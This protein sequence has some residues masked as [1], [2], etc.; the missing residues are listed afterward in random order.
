METT[1]ELKLHPWLARM[2][3][4]WTYET[5][6]TMPDGTI[7]KDGGTE[8][9]RALGGIWIVASGHGSMGCGEG[10]TQICLG[11]Q[12]EEQHFVGTFLGSMMPQLWMYQGQLVDDGQRLVLDTEG[13]SFLGDGR[14]RYQD[15]LE[16]KG[17]DEREMSSQ[18]LNEQGEWVRFMTIRYRR[19]SE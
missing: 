9:V 4:E 6:C 17:E 1:T 7:S 13:P 3:G 8:S 10:R 18:V 5:E 15:I 14:A 12:P 11:F 16:W 2:V 19:R